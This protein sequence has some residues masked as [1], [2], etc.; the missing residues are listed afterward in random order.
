MKR[1][2]LNKEQV[3]IRQVALL[4]VFGIILTG[5]SVGLYRYYKAEMTRISTNSTAT[6][7]TSL[8]ITTN[9]SKPVVLPATANLAVPYAAQAPFGN[10]TVHEESCEEAA[11]VMYKEYLDGNKSNAKFEEGALD[12]FFRTMKNWQ[13]AHYGSEPDLTMEA[14]G[15]FAKEYY[16]FN[17]K[18]AAADETSIKTAI[19]SGNPVVVPVM[20]H[21]LQNSMYGPVSV[22]HVLLIKGYDATGV[23]TNDAGVGNGP[24]HHYDWNIL[25]Q[26]I[27]SQTSKMNQGRVMLTI[28]K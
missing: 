7:D 22:Y 10:W 6:R 5:A 1:R 16:G 27:D 24:D 14:L 19:A 3:Q 12:G 20:T 15:K 11:L 23:I 28:S 9:N 18:T 21:S 13:V 2:K 26:A 25:W 17:Y 8:T 4:F